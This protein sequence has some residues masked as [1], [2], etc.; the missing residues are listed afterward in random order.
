MEKRLLVNLTELLLELQIKLYSL[1]QQLLENGA[2][3]AVFQFI[4]LTQLQPQYKYI[5]MTMEL[6]EL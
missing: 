1:L 3:Y 6:K 4:M 5:M 2:W